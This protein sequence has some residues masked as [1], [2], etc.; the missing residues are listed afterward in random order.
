MKYYSCLAQTHCAARLSDPLNPLSSHSRCALVILQYR[1]HSSE[2]MP[3]PLTIAANDEIY[4]RLEVMRLQECNYYMIPD[5]LAPDWQ[6]R[7][8]VAE[9]D[10][11]HSNDEENPSSFSSPQ[12]NES[13]RE[14]ICEWCYRL[15]DHWELARESVSVAMNILDR[16]VSSRVTPPQTYMLA[17]LT[18]LHVAVKVVGPFKLRIDDLAELANRQFSVEDIISME[19]SMLSALNWRVH[20]PTA[21]GFCGELIDCTFSESTPDDVLDDLKE[22]ARYLTELSVCEYFFTT[23][24]PSSI[25]LASIIYAMEL[26]TD[27]NVGPLDK[28]RFT[29]RVAQVGLDIANE[30]VLQCYSRLRVMYENNLILI[31][32]VEEEEHK[33]MDD[34]DGGE[35]EGREHGSPTGVGQGPDSPYKKRKRVQEDGGGRLITE[36]GEE[37]ACFGPV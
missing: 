37:I 24:K 15:V 12:I 16:Y 23:R 33:D 22:M 6:A 31:D 18:S 26:T 28:D 10:F 3:S 13:W 1:I 30:D 20:P 8:A 14:K 4:D 25:A 29:R 21:A 27:Q 11:D 5:Y 34:C 32:Q 17:A 9:G 19:L 36:Y 2:K 7:L 35:V